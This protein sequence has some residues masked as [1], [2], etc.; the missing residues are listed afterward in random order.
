[1]EHT[2]MK[3]ALYGL[4]RGS[5]VDPAVLRTRAERAEQAGFEALWVGDHIALPA[6]APDP[7]DEPRLEALTALTYLAAATRSVRLG[8]G[9][10]VLPQRQPVLLAKQLSSLDVLSG[11]RL[12]VGVAVGYVEEELR[13]LGAVPEHRGAMTDEYIEAVRTLWVGGPHSF[14]G[15][16]V[17][18]TDVQMSPP[19]VQRPGPPII[20]G[21]HARAALRRAGR[22]GD[23][24]FGWG[25]TIDETTRALQAL[26]QAAEQAGRGPD[27]LEITIAPPPPFTHGA[28]RQYAEVGVH[29]LVLQPGD[30]TGTEID[31]VIEHAARHLIG[32]V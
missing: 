22:V 9:V 21:G 1:M 12:T 2:T 25:L 7:A 17:R 6:S 19:P 8:V 23:G 15:R 31:D 10:L 20:V 4:H 24:W 18:F 32:H 11:G 28:A 13:A 16:W 29:R 5:S 3:F 26:G 27:E 30:F 14:D